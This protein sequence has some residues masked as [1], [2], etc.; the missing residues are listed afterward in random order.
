MESRDSCRKGNGP[1][2]DPAALLRRRFDCLRA[3]F[4]TVI[5]PR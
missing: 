5:P 2:T 3:I 4:D 1:V